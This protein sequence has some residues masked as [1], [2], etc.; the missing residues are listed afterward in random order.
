MIDYKKRVIDWNK[1]NN[2]IN[3]AVTVV[4]SDKNLNK[5]HLYK[6]L[7]LMNEAIDQDKFEEIKDL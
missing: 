7:H 5:D 3:M 2:V 4:N 1:K 6:E